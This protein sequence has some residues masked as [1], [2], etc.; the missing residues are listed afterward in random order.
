MTAPL[1]VG[2]V[3]IDGTESA[4][5]LRE[6]LARIVLDEMYQFVGLL[7]ADGMTL[8][9]NHAALFGAGV[10][11]D[12]IRGKPFWEARWFAVSKETTEQQRDFV[13]RA[14]QGEFIRCDME[15]YG[16]AAGE[17]TIVV[18]FSLLPVR[19]E[20]GKVVFLLA[21]GRNITEKKRAEAEVALKNAELGAMVE[22]VRQF[23]QQRSDL[24]ANVS[25]EFR[26]PLT[27]ILGSVDEMRNAPEPLTATQ[28]MHLATMRRNAMALLKHVNDLLDLAKL[29]ADKMAMDYARV[30]VA[31]LIRGTADVFC[32]L[33]QR[34]NVSFAVLAPDRLPAEVDAEKIERIVVNLLSNAFK[35]APQGGRV[36][37]TLQASPNAK[38]LLR[39]Q[40]SGPGVAPE[41]RAAIFERFRQG[42]Q[43]TRRDFG[44][45]GLG[46]AIA[47]EFVELHGGIISVTDAP[48]GGALFL[49]EIP[50]VAPS[51][52]VVQDD[53]AF[54]PPCSM[55]RALEAANAES[56]LPDIETDA[57]DDTD[58][59]PSIL[60]V[61]DN[62]EMRRFI[63]DALGPEYRIVSAPNG[64]A[65]LQAAIA[66]PPDLVLTDLMLPM[67]GGD[68]LVAELRRHP[69]LADVPVLVLSAKDDD[70]LRARLLEESVQDYVTKP[71]SAHELRARVRNL[72]SMKIAR[73]VLRRELNSQTEDLAQLT[74]RLIA[75]RTALQESEFRWWTIYQHSPVG[76]ALIDADGMFTTANPAFHTMVAYAGDEIRRVSLQRIAPVEDRASLDACIASLVSG[77]LQQQHA[78]RRL[79]K[80]TGELIWV[81]LS[82]AKVPE[83]AGSGPMMVVVAEDITARR[84]A[85]HALRRAN[86]ELARVSRVSTLGELAASIAHEVNQ[87]LAAIATNGHACERWLDASPPNE[88]EARAAVQRI[89]RDANRAGQVIAR[90]RSFLTRREPK[91]NEIQLHELV[92]DV[93]SLVQTE[94][95]THRVTIRFDPAPEMPAVVADRIQIQQVV[96]NLAMNA[97][98]S[99][100][101]TAGEARV[102]EVRLEAEPPACLTLRMSDTGAGIDP[103]LAD[104]IFDAFETTKPEGMGMGLA[105]SRSIIEAH[106]GKLWFEPN[107][108]P[109]VTFAFTLTMAGME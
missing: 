18:D 48:G 82:V 29:D 79:Q 12:A 81:N 47:K 84:T 26:T 97:L 49:V 16:R 56:A 31:A 17:E 19:D 28:R 34:R 100:A 95:Q 30:D 63:R 2:D 83:T 103:A 5:T 24:F 7:D 15:V 45:T 25:H 9:I 36:S 33:A 11:L 38:L 96:L 75:N 42:Q 102:L 60:Q 87:P 22:K 108:G 50:T 44:G 85:E 90:I 104:R 64:E 53:G 57:D 6:K 68:Q 86:D 78:K 98:E 91:R 13:R 41:L 27:L 3:R 107:Q 74:R 4:T 21:E 76:I 23:D 77:P 39:V 62:I 37:C 89:V 88:P 32:A 43:G 51:G 72:V 14:R 54:A 106:G 93:I 105:I 58:A 70:A 20:A 99:I 71:F 10:G 67:L 40:D 46:L 69:P 55:D 101:R 1:R 109:G 59:R 73:D 94:A 80:K 35:F 66:S 61:E 65:A 52:A 92:T 8:E